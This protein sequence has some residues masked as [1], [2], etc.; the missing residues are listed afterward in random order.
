MEIQKL[1]LDRISSFP[2][3]IIQTILSLMPMRDAFRTSIL[4][5]N[6][7]DYCLNIPKLVFDDAVFQGPTCQNTS[8]RFKP[9]Y[10]IY[11]ILLLHQ[12]PILDFSLCMSQLK[13]SCEIDQIILSLS[14]NPTVKKLTLCIRTGDDHKL[15]PAFFKLQQLT[16]LKLQ[17]CA[18]QPPVTF[19][20]FSRLVSLSFNNVSITAKSF[21]SSCP[22]LND[23][24][25]IGD[26]NHLL[27]C[28]N[29]DF[30]ELFECLP[31][32]E[33]LCMSWYPIKC[34]VLEFS[35][36]IPE[37]KGGC[38]FDQMILHLSRSKALEKFTLRMGSGNR[39]TLPSSFF[40]MQSLTYLK[41]QRCTIHP[42]TTFSAFGRLTSLCFNNVYISK[43]ALLQFLSC[44]PVIKNFTPIEDDT[45]FSGE[46][47]S[48]FVDLFQ[49]LPLV[50]HLHMSCCPV[51]LFASDV[52]PMKFANLIVCLNV[53][54][55]VGLSFAEKDELRFVLLLISNSPNIK[56]IKL[57]MHSYNR[58]NVVSQIDMDSFDP[59]DYSYT[60]LEHLRV[61]KMTEFTGMK[62]EMDFVKLI[63]AMSPMLQKVRLE[64]DTMI[65]LQKKIV[66][67]EGLLELPR[68]SS[69]AKIVC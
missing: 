20:G 68:A 32:V 29:S 41:L 14:R 40:S 65:D 5:Q 38:E 3:N 64:F 39:Y 6:W 46:V 8:I 56:K 7:R 26:E 11:P 48:K 33:N 67:L 69:R 19:K 35:L 63:L 42:S 10:I 18:F 36:Y 49:R 2:P 66:S 16:V 57:E 59:L 43:S 51:K 47:S 22:Q 17:N 15:L 34:P 25:L 54:R 12:G 37:L 52:I 60:S 13:S 62:P 24:T 9:L 23:F 58:K 61:L 4:S 53:L 21:L 30:V 50:E 27:G 55:L 31:L 28:W 45:Y 44:C 1:P